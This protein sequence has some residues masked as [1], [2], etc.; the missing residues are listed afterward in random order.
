MLR[1]LLGDFLEAHQ[2]SVE[3]VADAISENLIDD[4]KAVSERYIR[5]LK[6]NR[7]P[8]DTT[9]PNRK[10][11]LLMLGLIIRA[12]RVLTKKPVAISD[13]LEYVELSDE[14]SDSEKKPLT[15]SKTIQLKEHD[16]AR[17]DVEPLP[18]LD[19]LWELVVQKLEDKNHFDLSQIVKQ[20]SESSSTTQVK[21]KRL[22]LPQ[23]LIL[24]IGVFFITTG[25]YFTYDQMVANPRLLAKYSRLFSFRDRVRPTSDIPVPS[26]I[27]PEGDIDQL[28]PT[29]RIS[30]VNEAKAYE[31]YIE[32]M[33]SNDG[34]YTGPTVSTTFVIPENSLCP[35][36]SY[37]WRVRALGEDGWTSFSSP[38][39]FFVTEQ[40]LSE[41]NGHLIDLA[42][43]KTRP[44]IPEV[45]S[46][47]S[48]TN[49]AT[50][51]LELSMNDAA[52]GYGFYIRDLRTDA[53]VYDDNFALSPTL[54]IP[55]DVLE[56][57]GVYQW[58]ARLRNCH[59]WSEFTAA[60][61]FTVNL[62]ER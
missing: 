42:E 21:R 52:L 38:M 27:G 57:G 35:N 30:Q 31:F 36:T 16:L 53:L 61:V 60:Q 18:K 56:D 45:S 54:E 39:R 47:M 7:Q 19:T 62:N 1:L 14:F 49:T 4:E 20:A 12:L 23:Q 33:V 25:G 17:L 50:P 58:N 44:E 48:S 5:Y 29:L 43:D 41:T 10:P 40:A 55:E 13:I 9:N 6:S 15:F 24:V 46:L 51:V 37:E 26:L 3:E 8:L 32:N 2:L 11:S 22:N 59:Y 34:A 28:T